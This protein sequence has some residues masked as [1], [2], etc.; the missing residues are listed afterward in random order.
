MVGLF[1]MLMGKCKKIVEQK[2]A[3]DFEKKVKEIN[4]GTYLFDN[5][6]LLKR[7]KILIRT[8]PKVSTI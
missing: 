5:K 4:T 7:L 1:A 6:R 3:N 8:M 2:D